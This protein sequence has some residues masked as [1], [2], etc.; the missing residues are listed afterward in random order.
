M[1]RKNILVTG[2][3][4]RIGQ[5]LFEGLKKE[6]RIY[7]I[8]TRASIEERLWKANISKIDQLRHAMIGFPK[9]SAIVHLAATTR[10]TSDWDSVLQTNIV[11]TRNIY[12]IAK[13]LNIPKVIFA[14]TNHVT[15]FY[16]G[17]PPNLHKE[18][19]PKM[20]RVS[21]P[22]RPDSLYGVSKLFGEAIARFFYDAYGIESICLRIGS[23]TKNDDPSRDNRS[24]KTWLSH[25]DLIQLLRLSLKANIPFGIYYGVS[26]NDG[27]FWSLQNAREDLGYS[28]VDNA[29]KVV[30]SR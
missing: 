2:L 22:V 11:G 6:Y 28:P 16:E 5:I 15:G 26:N 23:V 24:H 19:N 30:N 13:E 8:D 4:G 29:K 1:E 21:D 20:I 10:V 17:D 3:G 25:R 7:G 12:Q 18:D 9:L 14:S 27:A